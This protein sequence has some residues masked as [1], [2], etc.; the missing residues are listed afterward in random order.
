[1]AKDSD[2]ILIDDSGDEAVK[3]GDFNIDDGTLDDCY[4]IFRLNKGAWKSDVLI[5]P[6]LQLMINAA[7]PK[8]DIKQEI[9]IS[10]LRD[11]KE[12]KSLDIVDGNIE[13]EI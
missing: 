7:L 3:D 2:D 6:N 4:I 12:A 8:T 13:F 11:G 5:G 10:L 1:M 9:A